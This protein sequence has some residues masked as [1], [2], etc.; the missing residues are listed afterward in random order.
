MAEVGLEF[1]RMA[2]IILQNAELSSAAGVI[3]AI[4]IGQIAMM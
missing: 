4:L 3:L 2:A 1:L